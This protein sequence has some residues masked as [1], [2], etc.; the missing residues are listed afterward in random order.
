MMPAVAVERCMFSGRSEFVQRG[1]SL[2]LSG[3]LYSCRRL[4]H[5]LTVGQF[6]PT[7]AH[8]GAVAV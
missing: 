8:V 4:N 6:F 7:D 3:L 1:Q 2:T 5:V